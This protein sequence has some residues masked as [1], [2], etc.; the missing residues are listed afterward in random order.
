M[1]SDN[2]TD[3]ELDALELRITEV[4]KEAQ[5]DLHKEVNDYFAKFTLRDKEMQKLVQKTH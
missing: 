3:K 4:F 2:W 5:K 1:Y